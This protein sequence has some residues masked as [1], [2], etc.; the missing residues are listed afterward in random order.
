MHLEFVVQIY[1]EQVEGGRFFLHEQPSQAGSWA[2]QC[3]R[4]LSEVPGVERVDSDQ[5]QYGQEVSYGEYRGSLS[6][7]PIGWM[8]NA[9]RSWTNSGSAVTGKLV[10]APERR[11]AVTRCVQD[12]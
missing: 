5:C 9:Q 2:E 4:D 7:K 11:A 8:S 12:A 10:S 3:V 6:K 1:H